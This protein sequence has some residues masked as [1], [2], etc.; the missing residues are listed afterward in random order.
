MLFGIYKAPLSDV[1]ELSELFPRE[2]KRTEKPEAL[3]PCQLLLQNPS[4]PLRNFQHSERRL[5][6]I[7][8]LVNEL[9][10]KSQTAWNVMG[11]SRTVWLLV[12]NSLTKSGIRKSF[13]DDC[14]LQAATTNK[15][16]SKS[17]YEIGNATN[18][19]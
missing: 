1:S 18:H 4:P 15:P 2:I 7:P 9:L 19:F 16:D 8:D 17:I 12:N 13:Q 14:I 3:Y 10:T 11:N 6:L 5:F